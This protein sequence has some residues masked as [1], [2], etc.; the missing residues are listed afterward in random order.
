MLPGLAD[1]ASPWV[2]VPLL[3][4]ELGTALWLVLRGLPKPH[5]ASVAAG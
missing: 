5:A 3:I 2:F 1:V 4:F